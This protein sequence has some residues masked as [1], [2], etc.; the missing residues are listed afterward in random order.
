MTLNRI[1]RLLLNIKGATVDDAEF[2]SD[3][4]HDA[5]RTVHVHVQKKYRWRCPICGKTCHVHDYVR[6]ES[7]WRDMDFGSV[8][9]WIGAKAPRVSCPE[10][11]VL[12]AHVPWAKAD[13]D[14]KAKIDAAKKH[15]EEIKH[16][17]YA[18]G[19]NPENLTTSQ[20]ARLELI[21]AEDPRLAR[22]HQLKK[23]LRIILR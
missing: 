12:R 22:A 5:R 15:V 3:A 17:R 2:D 11:G 21:Q 13:E 16:S 4:R 6:Q 1:L 18:L 14:S 7:F 23:R 10:H 9:V 8:A 19:K 20:R